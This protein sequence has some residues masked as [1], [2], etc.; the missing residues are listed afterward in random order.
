MNLAQ[1]IPQTIIVSGKTVRREPLLDK[2]MPDNGYNTGWRCIS[3]GG[4]QKHMPTVDVHLAKRILGFV[5]C[6]Q[7][8]WL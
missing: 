5:A 7:R 3:V 2:T 4:L 1:A 8:K 6:W